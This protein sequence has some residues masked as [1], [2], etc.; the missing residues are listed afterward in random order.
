M[1]K[2][3]LFIP[4]MSG[5][6]AER[7]F[8]R[9]AN[10]LVSSLGVEVHLI[11][12][13]SSGPNLKLLSSSV[14][15]HELNSFNI[16]F[17]FFSLA[18]LLKE[19]KIEYVMSTIRGA[20]IAVS[21]SRL[22]FSDYRWI[23]R[24]ANTFTNLEHDESR[25]QKVINYLCKVLYHRADHIIANS[26]DTKDD[27][28]SQMKN[29]E[30]EMVSILPN[31]V[32][33][34]VVSQD[35]FSSSSS[36]KKII[37]IGR[38][39]YQKDYPLMLDTIAILKT[40]RTDFVLDVY[41]DGSLKNELIN[42]CKDRS[43][44]DYVNFKGYSDSVGQ[45]LLS[46][47]LFLLT[48]HWEGFGNVLVEAMAAGTPIVSVLCPGGPRFILEKHDLIKTTSR[49]PKNIASSINQLLS[50]TIDEN[51]IESLRRLSHRFTSDNVCKMY[52]EVFFDE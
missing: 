23:L 43:I 8:A 46:S 6:G 16:I 15:I 2:V 34:G 24:E 9:Y 22:I 35:R 41:G 31:P 30:D 39:E 17:S 26:P 38:L 51:S 19:Q 10:Y 13:K 49:N 28:V 25:S 11:L 4:A 42:M 18:R 29:V 50:S 12:N 44:S 32:L 5:G 36:V 37:A 7:V 52:T 33:E 20:N 48:S 40:Y 45:C 1:K 3:A 14:I 27:I 47:D 21:L